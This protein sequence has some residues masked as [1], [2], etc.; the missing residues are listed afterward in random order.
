MTTSLSGALASL[1]ASTAL[2]ASSLSILDAGICDLPRLSKV[3]SQSR[4]FELLPSSTLAAAQASILAE[5]TPEVASLLS[6]V[7]AHLERLERRESSLKARWEL[8]EGRIARG[9][10]RGPAQSLATPGRVMDREH[11]SVGGNGAEGLR[12]TQMR[13]KKERLSYAVERLQLQAHQRERQLRK[14]MMAQ[15]LKDVDLADDDEWRE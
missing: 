15:N 1:Q 12:A 6:R 8:Q 13:H 2:L 7:E 3:V 9:T 11:A 5:L 4:H 10:E 14:S